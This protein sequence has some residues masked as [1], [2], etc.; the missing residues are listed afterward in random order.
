MKTVVIFGGSGF[1]GQHIIRRIARYGYKIIIPYQQQANESKIRLLGA[2]GQIFFVRFRSIN[3]PIIINQ[4]ENADVIINLKTIW[5]EKRISFQKGILDFNISLVDMLNKN[6]KNY[7]FIFFSGLGVDLDL[8]SKRS[9][10]IFKSE[11]YIE[12]NLKN[13]VIIRPSIII[14]GGDIFL[15][16]LLTFFR[17]S[18]FIP[19]FGNG[20]SKFQPVYIDDLSL[21]LCTIIEDTFVG[22]Q[23]FEFNGSKI[24]TYKE[25]YNFIAKCL[26]CRRVFVPIPFVIAKFGVFFLEKTPFSPINLEQLK[27]FKIDNIAS[28]KHKKLSDLGIKPQD[29]REIIKKIVKKNS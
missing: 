7:Q 17:M 2:T 3:E 8:D 9:E 6:K 19:L 11:N 1:V 23:I 4:I 28:L 18:F 26:G 24:F 20:E 5:N 25:F 21:G 27:L 13:T 22:N 10:A 29:L 16:G 14:G 15:K 12:Q